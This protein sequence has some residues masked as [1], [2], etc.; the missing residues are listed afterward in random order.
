MRLE[1]ERLILRSFTDA[2]RAPMAAIDA[3]PQVMRFYPETRSRAQTDAMIDSIQA[4]E[5]RDGFSFLAAEL[6]QTGAFVGLIGMARI[7]EP[8]ISVLNG[9][10]E[11]EIGWR[12]G[13]DFWGR[14]LA[15]EGAQACLEYAWTELQLD[16]VVAFTFEGNWPSRRVMEKLGMVRD[17]ADD[18]RHTNLPENHPI[19]RHVLYRIE[20]P[21]LP[22]HEYDMPF[23]PAAPR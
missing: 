17:P 19:S 12:F 4:A 13:A 18:F 14:G 10:P 2:D 3:D 16:E 7:G 23:S 8:L 6:R 9:R 11:V 1:T 15:P 22:D 5:A 21:E 20:R